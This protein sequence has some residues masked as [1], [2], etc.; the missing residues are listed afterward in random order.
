VILAEQQR[1]FLE[2][3]KARR[4]EHAALAIEI[5]QQFSRATEAAGREI[6]RLEAALETAR[7][8][9]STARHERE[10]RLQTLATASERLN[11]NELA[12]GDAYQLVQREYQTLCEQ[13]G[14]ISTEKFQ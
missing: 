7:G 9:Q 14:R 10:E 2:K 1:T 6:E 8:A 3:L 5:E 4:D 11:A 12:F 13:L